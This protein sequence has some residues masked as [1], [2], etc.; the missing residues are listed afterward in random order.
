MVEVRKR[1]AAKRDLVDIWRYSFEQWGEAHADAYA[2]QFDLAVQRLRTHPESGVDCSEIRSG[3]RRVKV[4]VHHLYYV[5][6]DGAIDI[7]R[8][9]DARR[10]ALR[11]LP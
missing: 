3:Y 4:G 7:V 2:D 8:V 9:L 5:Y 10:D 1:A 6:V 11:H